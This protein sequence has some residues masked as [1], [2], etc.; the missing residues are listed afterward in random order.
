M[1]LEDYILETNERMEKGKNEGEEEAGGLRL[2]A[3]L[4]VIC[5]TG[6]RDQGS[7]DGCTIWAIGGLIAATDLLD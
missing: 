4:L 5:D 6:G 2:W 3:V 7:G 1:R